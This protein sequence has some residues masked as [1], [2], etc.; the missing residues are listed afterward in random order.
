MSTLHESLTA[1]AHDALTGEYEL[2]PSHTRLGFVARHAM[3]TKVRGRFDE[4][5][6]R[7]HLDAHSPARSH[8]EVRIR[9][10][11]IDTREPSRDAHL[12]SDDF[13]DVQTYPEMTFASTGIE[14]LGD[15]TF[16]ITGDLTIKTIAR[17]LTFDLVHTG[18]VVDEEGRFRVGFEGATTVNRKDW[19]LS[20]NLALEAG[21]VLVGD[22]VILE[23][24]VSAVRVG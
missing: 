6:G 20:W 18:Q 1:A 22:K 14:Q 7:I 23:F 5:E 19:G 15:L 16:R 9:T 24:D 4:F 10:A 17:S 13:F 12:R 21:G 3:I 8:A 2:D 11:S